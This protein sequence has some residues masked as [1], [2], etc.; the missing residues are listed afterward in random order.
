[1]TLAGRTPPTAN[2]GRL[3]RLLVIDIERLPGHAIVPHRGL[4]V[5]GDF[6]DLNG[7]KH[8]I[9]RRINPDDVTEWPRTICAAWRWQGERRIHFASE[10]GDGHDGMV[11]AIWEAFDRAD[12]A[13]GHNLDGFDLKHCRTDWWLQ[14]LGEPAPFK[15]VDT[16]KVARKL[17]TESRTLDALLR[18]LGEPG[19][20]DKYQIQMARDAC[21]GVATAQKRIERYNKGD[22]GATERL[23]VSQR[24]FNPSHPHLGLYTG[25]EGACY[26]CGGTTFSR[27]PEDVIAL[28]QTYAGYR[29]DSC[30]ANV[31]P[32]HR[33][34]ITTMRPAR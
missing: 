17:G 15:T 31:R 30:G 29:C 33:R 16:L 8:T 14:G 27:L 3:P 4:T 25:V 1:M 28:S 13:I 5:E 11:Q 20:T 6:W 23:Y 21:A 18:R 22:I 9:G 24:G 32:N 12:V 19:K 10:W 2:G 34:R 7:W 26:S